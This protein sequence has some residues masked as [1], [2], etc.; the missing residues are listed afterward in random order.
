[1]W[2]RG[3]QR[4]TTFE[5]VYAVSV[6]VVLDVLGIVGLSLTYDGETALLILYAAVLSVGLFVSA[7][8]LSVLA[9]DAVT[10][11]LQPKVSDAVRRILGR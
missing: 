6:F 2:L 10:P 3:L 8:I 9:H 5:R 4:L 11:R 1:M 7:V